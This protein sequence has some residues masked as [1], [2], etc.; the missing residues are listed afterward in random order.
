MRMIPHFRLVRLRA[1]VRRLRRWRRHLTI[2]RSVYLTETL[3]FTGA[4]VFALTGRRVAVADGYG[5]RGDLALL[6][7]VIVLCALIHSVLS[8][9]IIELLKRRFAPPAYDER[10][11]LFDLG[12]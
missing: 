10:R 8:W 5:P 3:L 9:R 6:A 7:A 1:F 12:Q 2:T 11:I 4:L